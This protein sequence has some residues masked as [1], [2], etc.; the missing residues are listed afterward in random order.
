ML[1]YL[2]VLVFMALLTIASLQGAIPPFFIQGVGP[3][4]LRQVVLGTAAA[5]FAMSSL[6]FMIFYSKSRSEFLYWYS[7]ALALIAAGLSAV[8]LQKAVGSPIGWTGRSTQYLGGIYFIIAVLT[9]LRGARA[10]GIPLE[11]AIADFLRQAEEH[12]RA[13]VE[14][15]PDAIISCDHEGRVLLWNS[16]AERMFGYS[17]GEAVGSLLIDLIA[18]DRHADN[19]RQEMEKFAK[20]GKGPLS[21]KAT[22]IEAKRKNGEVFP[23]ELSV[24]VGKTAA[25]W[26]STIISKG[27]H[28]AQAGGGRDQA[29]PSRAGHSARR[30]PATGQPARPE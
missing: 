19:L 7:L 26:V 29:T 27:H 14:T 18:P 17:R 23:V 1:A 21:G 10:K 3:T 9:A 22:E 24:S 13:L 4:L 12:Y 20:T 2:G 15:V 8:F 6:L 25:G 30:Q 11:K 5:L 16:A 28:R